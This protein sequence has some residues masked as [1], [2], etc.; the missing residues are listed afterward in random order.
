MGGLHQAIY[1]E[2]ALYRTFEAFH[3]HGYLKN[4]W[5]ENYLV[6]L[7]SFLYH[8]LPPVNKKILWVLDGDFGDA[9]A[10][11][12]FTVGIVLRNS[13]LTDSSIAHL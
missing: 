6:G 12:L 7:L 10:E 9:E 1:P 8:N 3:V 2:E 5:S 13:G 4:G 11:V